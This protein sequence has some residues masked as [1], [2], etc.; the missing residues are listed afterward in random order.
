MELYRYAVQVMYRQTFSTVDLQRV[1]G[2]FLVVS[3]LK[4]R[5]ALHIPDIPVCRVFLDVS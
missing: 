4:V 2:K 5:D 3:P 1:S